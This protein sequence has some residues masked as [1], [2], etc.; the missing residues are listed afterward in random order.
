MVRKITGKHGKSHL[1]HLKDS[2]GDLITDKTDIASTIGTTFE[3]N[4]SSENY[5]EKFQNIKK[6]EEEKILNFQTNEY[7]AYNKRFKLRDLKRSIKKSKDS[8]PGPDN[9]HYRIL[10]N[11]PNETLTILLNIINSRVNL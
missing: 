2:N 1:L 8:T 10:K 4:S 11:L 9:V 7:F 3:K 6:R 5:S